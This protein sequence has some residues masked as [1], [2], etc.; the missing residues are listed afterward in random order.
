MKFESSIVLVIPVYNEEFGIREFIRELADALPT[1]SKS[2]VVI[3]DCSRDSSFKILQS[4]QTEFAK[5][6]DLRIYRNEY[7]LGHGPSVVKGL[8]FAIG[9]AP[10][11]ILSIDG[12]GQ[13]LGEDVAKVFLKFHSST[14]DVLEASRK[15]RD[16]PIYRKMVSWVTRAIVF[17]K[18]GKYPEDANTPLRIYKTKILKELINEIPSDTLVPN[19]R[20]SI[21]SRRTKLNIAFFPVTSIPRRGASVTGTTWNTQKIHVPSQKFIK[22]CLRAFKEIITI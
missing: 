14:F 19:L 16:E 8:K 22:F 7:N 17:L 18:S 3:D 1:T 15:L 6:F 2:F 10:D 20:I 21:K 9:L 4:M 5:E 12:D 11:F 13:F